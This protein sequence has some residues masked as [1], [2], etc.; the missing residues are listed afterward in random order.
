MLSLALVA[1]LLAMPTADD[2]AIAKALSLPILGPRK[3]LAELQGYV[4]DRIPTMPVVSSAAE[5]TSRAKGYRA[6][7][8]KSVVFRGEAAGWREMP[9]K[10]EF[11]GEVEGGSGYRIKKLRFQVIPGLWI[12]A[13]MYE[14]LELRGKVPVVLNVNG[15]DS[16]G[17]SADYKQIRCINQAKRGMIALNL[18]W[19]GMGQLSGPG[20]RHGLINAIDLTGTSGIAL[21]YLAMTRGI[22]ILLAHENADPSRVG[23][24]GLSGGG[25]QTIFV[26]SLDDRVTLTDPVAGYSSFRTRIRE[27]SDLGDSEQTPSDL[28][29]VVDY[30][31]LTAMMAPHPTLLTFNAKDNCCFAA[32]HALPPLHD[33]A[34]P[35]FEIFGREGNFRAHINDDPGTH[36]YE[37]DNRQALYQLMADHW[38]RPGYVINP[39]EIPSISE[40]KT[41]E[42]LN[43]E[44]PSGNLNFQTLA[45]KLSSDLP[46]VKAPLTQDKPGVKN[47]ENAM[48]RLRS[49]VRPIS[50]APEAKKVESM[51]QDGITSTLWQIRA[52]KSW[53]I[54]AVEF[55]R[56]NA[57]GT[58]ILVGDEGRGKLTTHTKRLLEEGR[59]VVVADLYGFGEAI[60]PSHVYLFGLVLGT[61]GERPLGIDCGELMAL[62]AWRTEMD[63][64]QPRI[65]AIG[66]RSGVIAMV[67]EA[68]DRNHLMDTAIVRGPVM[69]LKEIIDSGRDYSAS[70]EIFCFGLLE[71]FDLPVL[72]S[73]ARPGAIRVEAP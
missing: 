11:L 51:T 1:S 25:W 35:I 17:K 68:L 3:T 66:P 61:V 53:T 30:T 32:P 48:L 28:A 59:R 24:T 62:A 56:K 18:E 71:E 13:I 12:P 43:V 5:W 54:P 41:S 40:I 73:L 72:Q 36:N 8:L 46:H 42:Q 38:S 6:S 29:T 52:G 63:G 16:K 4:E 49:I 69:S 10:A 31:H 15:H 39:K 47:R 58:T 50:G 60:P 70:P 55:G 44:L 37:I 14:P 45:I 27:F 65:E 20:F 23:V 26:S 19:F 22:D 34:A 21:H 7:V 64:E 67:A 33:A 9:T 2:D 57:K